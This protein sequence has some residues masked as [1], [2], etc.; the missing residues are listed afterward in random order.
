MNL[1][2]YFIF[3]KELPWQEVFGFWQVNE[4][5]SD[6]WIDLY[7]SRGY[8]N[9]SEWRMTY[10]EP[11][12]MDKLDW[13]LYD[14]KDPLATVPGFYCGPFTAWQKYYHR[15]GLRQ[16]KDLIRG[17]NLSAKESKISGLAE[18]FPVGV[19]L[20][21]LIVKNGIVIIE[22]NHRCLVLT[23]M[24]KNKR[25]FF[26]QVSIA[27]AASKLDELPVIGGTRN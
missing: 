8:S 2:R 11:L 5:K 13:K 16:Y 24:A 18:N 17:K 25:K 7:R 4:S 12:L 10:V 26:G 3:E 6:Y 19:I 15:G 9:W 23:L 21:G 1:E 22:G 14:I 20:I 27:L